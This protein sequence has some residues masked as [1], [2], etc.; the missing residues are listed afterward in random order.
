MLRRLLFL[1]VLSTFMI[2]AS[3]QDAVD[4]PLIAIFNDDMYQLEGDT[5]VPYNACMPDEQLI[6]QYIQSPDGLRFLIVTR[7]KIVQQALMEMGSL[8]GS[9]YGP[10]LWL[11][12]TTTDSVE[13]ILVQP[14]ADDEFTGELPISEK[15]ES[16]PA[17]SPD[18]TQIVWTQLE[19]MGEAQAVVI[20]DVAT[21]STQEFPVELPPA[22]FPAPP[23]VI[24]NDAGIVLSI[25]TLDEETFLNVE[26]LLVFDVEFGTLGNEVI[27]YNGGE[28]DD[29]IA[30]RVFVQQGDTVALALRYYNS[31]WVLIDIMTGEQSILDSLPQLYNPMMPDA[32]VLQMDVDSNYNIQWQMADASGFELNAYPF[33]RVVLAPDGS[34][35][36]YADAV[37]HIWRDGQIIDIANSDGFADDLRAT[38]LWL[39]P[40]WRVA[41]GDAAPSEPEIINCE[42]APESRLRVGTGAITTINLNVRDNPTTTGE[43]IGELL[44]ETVVSVV[45]G[46]ECADGYAWYFVQVEGLMGWVAEGVNED[47]FIAPNP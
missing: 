45:N 44:P 35:F 30:E 26:K 1:L 31:G 2:P 29:F 9:V 36:A 13:R 25:S 33:Q 24:W 22:P 11:C 34:G 10:N 28:T 20:Y 37:L 32:P 41:N 5:L 38:L 15:V 16:R 43:K 17:W 23:Q 12:D 40:A 39:P 42:G 21:G 7:T 6:G 18:G 3:A 19:L 14:N 27:F 46:P 8:G 47:Y 4:I